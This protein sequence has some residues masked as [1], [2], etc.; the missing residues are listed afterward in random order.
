M[1]KES[2]ETLAPED[3]EILK[4]LQSAYHS[5]NSLKESPTHK[6]ILLDLEKKIR[7]SQSAK[8]K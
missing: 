5:I 6:K 7:K 2:P 4:R 3:D 1:K 8:A